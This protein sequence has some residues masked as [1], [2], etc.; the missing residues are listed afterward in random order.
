[1]NR[2][3]AGLRINDETR[4]IRP[5]LTRTP[6]YTDGQ[7]VALLEDVGVE[8]VLVEQLAGVAAGWEVHA[9]GTGGGN[10]PVA[11]QRGR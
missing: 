8:N 1:M 3:V 10:V 6:P 9:S 7:L 2:V 5:W 11:P 4:P